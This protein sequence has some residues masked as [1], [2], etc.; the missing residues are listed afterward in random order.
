MEVA[1]AD[2]VH[3]LEAIIEMEPW[4]HVEVAPEFQT[5]V[6][7]LARNQVPKIRE[8]DLLRLREQQRDDA[9]PPGAPSCHI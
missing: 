8:S 1:H 6:D 7:A 9:A 2:A 5:I 4:K 3:K